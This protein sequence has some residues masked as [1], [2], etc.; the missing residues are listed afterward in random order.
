MS[1]C[2]WMGWFLAF[3]QTLAQLL[4]VIVALINRDH[5]VISVSQWAPAC[6]HAGHSHSLPTMDFNGFLASYSRLTCWERR[7]HRS[8]LKQSVHEPLLLTCKHIQI[9]SRNSI[10]NVRLRTQS[11]FCSSQCATLRTARFEFS[12]FYFHHRLK[13]CE[14]I[15]ERVLFPNNPE[16]F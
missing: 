16:L 3:N 11:T 6:C 1:Y 5:G 13:N 7:A 10:W 12:D 8:T 2:I 4:N 9:C 14:N 15:P